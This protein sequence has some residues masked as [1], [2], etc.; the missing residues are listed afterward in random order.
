MKKAGIGDSS[1]LAAMN[2]PSAMSAS[3]GMGGKM[4]SAAASSAITG[5]SVD[6]GSESSQSKIDW[7]FT[8]RG[9]LRVIETVA[10]QARP[11]PRPI[12]PIRSFVFPFTFTSL[13]VTPS[14]SAMAARM[15]SRYGPIRGV[16]AT[17]TTSA[18]TTW[19]PEP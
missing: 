1:F 11:S 9:L 13:M 6:C 14:A 5:R 12:Q 18:L 17:T 19:N 2:A 16:S 8:C 15:A 10:R 4:F 7:R 3:A